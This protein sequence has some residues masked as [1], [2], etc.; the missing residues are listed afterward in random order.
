[1]QPCTSYMIILIAIALLS[2][3]AIMHIAYLIVSVHDR[4][5]SEMM[6]ICL[7]MIKWVQSIFCGWVYLQHPYTEF[8]YIISM[9][10]SRNKS[11]MH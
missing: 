7:Q 10:L 1:M 4:T 11:H 8:K 2:L 6:I 9:T 5:T 3:G